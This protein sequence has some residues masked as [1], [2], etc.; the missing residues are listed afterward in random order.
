MHFAVSTVHYLVSVCDFTALTRPIY[1]ETRAQFD[2][3]LKQMCDNSN[4]D[5]PSY[6]DIE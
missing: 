5:A 3:S 2:C 4:T 6:K 1:M